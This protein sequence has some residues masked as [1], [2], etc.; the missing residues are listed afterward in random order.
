MDNV[1]RHKGNGE[2]HNAVAIDVNPDTTDARRAGGW[3]E[4]NKIAAKCSEVDRASRVDY[5]KVK[6]VAGGGEGGGKNNGTEGKIHLYVIGALCC[7]T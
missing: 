7:E 5:P 4:R 2:T 6:D 3:L 1:I